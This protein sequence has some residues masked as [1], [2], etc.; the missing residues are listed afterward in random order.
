MY[1]IKIL[2]ETIIFMNFIRFLI[3]FTRKIFFFVQ[4]YFSLLLLKEFNNNIQLQIRFNSSKEMP[5]LMPCFSSPIFCLSLS[6]L[7]STVPT[8]NRI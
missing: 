8:L 1:T 2:R 4:F 3:S 5:Y 6:V 7:R